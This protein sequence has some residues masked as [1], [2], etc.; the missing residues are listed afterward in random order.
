MTNYRKLLALLLVLAMLL[1]SACNSTRKPADEEPPLT[2]SPE[3]GTPEQEEPEQEEEPPEDPPVHVELTPDTQ[4]N[5]ANYHY[6]VK[7]IG[8]FP[9]FQGLSF[10]RQLPVIRSAPTNGLTSDTLLSPMAE[11]LLGTTC[12]TFEYFGD[13]L[14]AAYTYG[15]IPAPTCALV[16]VATGDVLLNDGAAR[17]SKL[18]D[19]YYYVIYV[20][21]ETEIEDNAFIYFT[22]RTEPDTPEA[23]DTLYMGY[24]KVYDLE[25][26]AFV[27]GVEVIDAASDVV[28]S[29]ETL[30]V[31]ISRNCYDL[32]LADGTVIAAV[33]NLYPGSNGLVQK[34]EKNCVV[35]DSEFNK[36]TH[37]VGVSPIAASENTYSTDYFA[38]RN[39]ENLIGVVDLNGE[40]VL[41]CAFSRI[42]WEQN[43]YF[44]VCDA[45]ERVALYHA[46]GTELA[47]F[48]YTGVTPPASDALPIFTLHSDEG[49]TAYIPGLGI[50]GAEYTRSDACFTTA[51]TCVM[52]AKGNAVPMPGAAPVTGAIVF[53][54]DGLVELIHGEL[55]VEGQ[56]LHAFGTGEYLYVLTEDYLWHV[57]SYELISF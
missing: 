4:Y 47:G 41:P 9:T 34:A 24:A 43:G 53:T 23:E 42:A 56:Y 11:D 51:D 32:H 37:V 50:A 26:S 55:L 30:C 13:G 29:G 57:Y 40:E 49:D 38:V 5:L 6:S 1:L 48:A 27:D 19:R 10:S 28:M 3:T 35:Y 8:T 2:E 15:E 45:E 52:L 14:A 31:E 12:H 54:A 21:E 44:A 18:S 22:A 17:I 36:I 39:A 46:D 16:N 20:T 25:K 7:E 33:E